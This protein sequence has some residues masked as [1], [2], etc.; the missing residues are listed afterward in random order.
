[1]PRGGPSSAVPR[2]GPNIYVAPPVYGFGMPFFGGYGMGMGGY[3]MGIPMFG[4]L[5][6]IFNIMIVM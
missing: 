4:G 5:S 3:G 1:M 6:F 2:A